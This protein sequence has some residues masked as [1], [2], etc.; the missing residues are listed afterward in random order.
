MTL[1][2]IRK[3]F[4]IPEYSLSKDLFSLHSLTEYGRSNYKYLCT[5]E[6]KGKSFNV[7]GY[8]P[9]TKMDIL[10]EQ[11]K[12]Y[13]S[14]LKYDSDYFNPSYRK[15]VAENL[16]VH[17][18]LKSLGFRL[19]KHSTDDYYVLEDKDIYGFQTTNIRI[20]FNG[21]DTFERKDVV[22]INLYSTNTMWL[23]IKVDNNM[24]DLKSGIDSI[25]KPLLLSESVKNINKADNMINSSEVDYIMNTLKNIDIKSTDYKSELRKRLLELANSI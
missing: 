7:I 20:S 19:S 21:L 13:I 4:H 11:V 14:N 15:G 24:D 17:D 6:R 3:Y 10:K 25:L 22:S 1:K 23:S 9:T 16:F 12:D 8:N 18:Y 2:E 5:V